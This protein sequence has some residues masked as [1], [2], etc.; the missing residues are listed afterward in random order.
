VLSEDR[1]VL[2]MRDAAQKG[3]TARMGI[4][5]AEGHASCRDLFEN[6]A[7]QI[8]QLVAQA[9]ALPGCIGAKMTGGGWGGCTVNLVFAEAAPEFC[10]A[11]SAGYTAQTGNEASVYACRAARGAYTVKV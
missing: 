8:D 4:L 5:L 7:P 3:D 6:S 9:V 1:R 11:L 10:R 2:A